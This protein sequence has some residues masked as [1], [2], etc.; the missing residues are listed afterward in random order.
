M[1]KLWLLLC[2]TFIMPALADQ[3][4]GR[5][6]VEF[7]EPAHRHLREAMVRYLAGVHEV[8]AHMASGEY[9]AAA[10]AAENR[11]G[12]GAMGR[13]GT[14]MGP[15]RFMPA[16]MRSLAHG[17]HAAGSEL[18]EAIRGGDGR[19]MTVALERV[20]SNCTACHSSYTAKVIE[21][22]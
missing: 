2:L 1:R 11:V 12:R 19:E 16:E 21:E 14:G 4:T 5:V 3:P 20:L 15:G 7:P 13:H 22:N 17:M 8:V 6:V 9:E 10:E 18:A